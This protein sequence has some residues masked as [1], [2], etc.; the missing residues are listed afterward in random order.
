MALSLSANELEM[1][2]LGEERGREGEREGGRGRNYHTRTK[3][4]IKTLNE[5]AALRRDDGAAPSRR[6]LG[7]NPFE[8]LWMIW[9]N[10]MEI[11]ENKNDE[12]AHC[13]D[14]NWIR[15]GLEVT[16]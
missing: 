14:V 4:S 1:M 11:K 2:G 13:F 12:V 9:K 8:I 3:F 6:R 5:D 7:P 16:L 10:V 15:D